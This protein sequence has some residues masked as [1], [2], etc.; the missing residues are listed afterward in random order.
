MGSL[1]PSRRYR[2]Q[3]RRAA[4]RLEGH[5]G[6]VNMA[7]FSPDGETLA[8]V[9][10]DGTVRIWNLRTGKMRAKICGK[11]WG[12]PSCSLLSGRQDARD[13]E[14]EQGRD[15]VG[16]DQRRNPDET[17]GPRP[18]SQYAALYSPPMERHWRRP[19]DDTMVLVR[20]PTGKVRRKLAGHVQPAIALAYSPDSKMLVSGGGWWGNTKGGGELRAWDL[21]TGNLRWTAAGNFALV[22]G[23]SHLHRTGERSLAAS[24]DGSIR[25]WDAATGMEKQTLKGHADRVI[26]VAYTPTGKT[27]AS[28]SSDG[29]IRFWDA[30]TGSAK[31]VLKGHTASVQR[32]AFSP[33]G[34]MLATTSNDQSILVWLLGR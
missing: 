11:C 20:D 1:T 28:S 12:I 27:L 25:I 21:E 6:F 4:H 29:T 18:S 3:C 14:P 23:A 17:D 32:V 24:L 34:A 22:S 33:N 10:E 26:W 9:S 8:S 16:S 7:D 31:A 2:R 5:T 13:R 19:S 15:S 30:A